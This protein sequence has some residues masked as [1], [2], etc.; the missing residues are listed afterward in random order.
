MWGW[1][2]W[3]AGG[4]WRSSMARIMTASGFLDGV[5]HLPQ[6]IGN[7]IFV[8]G[9]AMM[10]GWRVSVLSPQL[11]LPQQ[12]ARQLRRKPPP[13]PARNYVRHLPSHR[14]SIAWFLTRARPLICQRLWASVPPVLIVWARSVWPIFPARRTDAPQASSMEER[15][16][17]KRYVVRLSEAEKKQLTSL[18]G[19]KVLAS[20]KRMRAQVLL[21][22]DAGAEGPA[23]IDGRIAEA[24]D[25]SVVTVE[26]I[27]K[28]YV[29]EGLEGAI[30]P[31]EAMS[32]VA[33]A[34]SRRPER[35]ASG[36]SVLWNG[37]SR[38][39]PLDAEP[40]GGQIGGTPDRGEDKQ[41][42]R[43]SDA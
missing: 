40:A 31:Q 22:A 29:L 33:A 37:A 1:R 27:R 30:E 36:G 34:G 28:D 18:L 8:N 39:W 43:P 26:K 19:K 42:N 16:M 35:S 38:A 21:K 41:G 25:V 15:S 24:F 6:V 2:V 12:A 32:P 20:K 3:E 23:W 10:W 14:R 11:N 4:V 9:R 17:A 5:L 7:S 13:V